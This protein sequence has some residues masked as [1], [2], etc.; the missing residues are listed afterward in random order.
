MEED[1]VEVEPSS[2][3]CARI[4]AGREHLALM[5]SPGNPYFSVSRLTILLRWATQEMK[6]VDVIVSD[7]EMTASTYLAQ[8][9]AEKE[10]YKKARA[11]I[12][13]MAS[14][15]RRA[16]EAAGDPDVRVSE[17]GEWSG[18]PEYQRARAYVRQA[19]T[20][21]TYR[22]LYRQGTREAVKARMPEG[23]EPTEHQIDAGLVHS[24]KALPFVI[25][26]VGIFGVAQVVTAYSRP[27]AQ[28]RYFFTP[29]SPFRASPGQ[30]YIGVRAREDRHG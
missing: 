10:A 14:R 24:E 4:L 20:D 3:N 15:I 29:H 8:G 19:L 28:F 25:N 26:A 9:R 27:A 22:A 2:D 18:H 21:P 16:R 6:R 12:R 1:L 30:A 17:F 23:W 7:L 11:D 5:V 13:Q